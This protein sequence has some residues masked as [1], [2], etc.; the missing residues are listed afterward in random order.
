MRQNVTGGARTI[1]QLASRT[2]SPRYPERV[3]GI[4]YECLRRQLNTGMPIAL[5]DSD[6]Q[7]IGSMDDQQLLRLYQFLLD[8]LRSATALETV[9]TVRVPTHIADRIKTLAY[10]QRSNR[11][12]VARIAILEYLQ[13]N[14]I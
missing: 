9:L 7:R 4:A 3:R 6:L 13:R 1:I 10:R 12:E 8:R 2:V 11:S 5:T 14:P